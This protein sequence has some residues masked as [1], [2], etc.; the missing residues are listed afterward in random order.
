MQKMTPQVL[1]G[2]YFAALQQVSQMQFKRRH[3]LTIVQNFKYAKNVLKQFEEKRLSLLRSYTE[4]ASDGSIIQEM[5]DGVK[6]PKFR[7]DKDRETYVELVNKMHT[8][9]LFPIKIIR[10][11]IADIPEGDIQPVILEMLEP[12]WKET[13]DDDEDPK[14][15]VP[16]M[17]IERKDKVPDPVVS[18]DAQIETSFTNDTVPVNQERPVAV[19]QGAEAS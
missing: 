4:V 9:E 8:T 12:M 7:S 6:V 18:D 3:A 1:Q 10:M 13:A 11:S 5:K 19:Q 15:E 14:G 17:T 2:E 16:V